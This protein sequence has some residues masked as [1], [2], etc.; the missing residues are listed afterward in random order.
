MANKIFGN[1]HQQVPGMV[2]YDIESAI[3]DAGSNRSH[4]VIINQQTLTNNLTPG[5]NITIEVLGDGLID[6]AYTLDL[7]SCNFIAYTKCFGSSITVSNMKEPKPKYWGINA[8]P[9]TTDTYSFIQK[10]INS[11]AVGGNI[12]LD[13]EEYYIATGLSKTGST[14]QKFAIRGKGPSTTIISTDQAITMLTLNGVSGSNKPDIYLEGLQINGSD[15]AVR[16]VDAQYLHYCYWRNCKIMYINGEGLY[17]NDFEDMIFDNFDI[18]R[19]GDYTNTKPA[20]HFYYSGSGEYINSVW[21]NN[22]S[23]EA[24][25][26]TGL[27]LDSVEGIHINS[28]K[29]HGRTS[30]DDGGTPNPV[31]LLQISGADR[32]EISLCQFAQ[33]RRWAINILNDTA[34]KAAGAKIINNSFKNSA[35]YS[36]T[37]G[38]GELGYVLIQRGMPIL[39]GNEFTPA[40]TPDSTYTDHHVDIKISS[41]AWGAIGENLHF[42]T[43][44][45]KLMNSASGPIPTI[46]DGD[47]K[48]MHQPVKYIRDVTTDDILQFYLDGE[49]YP[50]FL[51]EASGSLKWG[52]GSGA[53]DVVLSRANTNILAM[54]SGDIFR[55]ERF[56]LVELTSAPASVTDGDIVYA[57][58]TSWNPGSG[59]GFYGRENGAWVKL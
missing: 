14:A 1:S 19:C 53:Q 18:R 54:D 10:A 48:W 8:I 43:N 26:Y 51:I 12:L 52:N 40:D 47:N 2:T 38:D 45:S 56:R 5:S 28:C 49:S 15:V 44:Y 9:G 30:D 33:V 41:N 27:Y 36:G 13:G 24:N 4:F 16:G 35:D 7:N 39:I 50:R 23:I 58:G 55:S 17:A 25:K 32:V 57:D 42:G 37:L 46:W 34:T 20:L 59:E 11:V 21:L 6:G 22:C 31:D 29:F 3:S